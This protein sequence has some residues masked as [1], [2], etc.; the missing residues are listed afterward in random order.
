ML[1]LSD[2]DVLDSNM[3]SFAPSAHK[4]SSLKVIHETLSVFI[5]ATG[6]NVAAKSS[7]AN[8]GA[9]PLPDILPGKICITERLHDG[10][11]LIQWIHTPYLDDDENGSSGLSGGGTRDSSRC[12]SRDSRPS[13]GD[14]TDATWAVINPGGQDG[15]FSPPVNGE[16]PPPAGQPPP[17]PPRAP[18]SVPPP[19]PSRATAPSIAFEKESLTISFAANTDVND[20]TLVLKDDVV[21]V[22]S[23]T[24]TVS[25]N[26]M[27][28]RYETLINFE[29]D[30][31]KSFRRSPQGC[32]WSYLVLILA[33]GTTLPALHFHEG[34]SKSFIL[35]LQNYVVTRQSANDNRLF[36]VSSAEA[37]QRA[38]I[39]SFDELNLF[40]ESAPNLMSKLVNDPVTTTL[41]GFSRVTN[42]LRDQL[43]APPRGSRK[44]REDLQD[45]FQDLPGLMFTS[46]QD[47]PDLEIITCVST[48]SP[49]G[50]S[51]SG[52]GSA[53]S[54]GASAT[55]THDGHSPSMVTSPGASGRPPPGNVEEL[56]PRPSVLRGTPITSK[57]WSKH[58]NSEG[59]VTNVESLKQQI[60]RGGVEPSLR[61]EVW[62]FLLGYYDYKSTY[63]ERQEERKTRVDDYF[64]MKLQWKSL[65]IDQESRFSALKERKA[66]IEKDVNRTDRTH[67]FFQ[68]EKNP[69]LDVLSDVLMTYVMFNFD[70]G[71]VQGMSDLLAPILVV[72]E[73]EVD[74]FWCF[75]G[76]MELIGRNFEMDQSTMKHQMIQL[77][78]ILEFVD[79]QLMEYLENH[80]SGNLYFCFRWLLIHFKR[81]FSFPDIMRIW[82]VLWTGHPCRNFHL[83]ICVALLDSEKG[84]LVENEFGFTEILKHINDMSGTI[85]IETTLRKAEAIFLQI[86]GCRSPPR[87]VA[88]ILGLEAMLCPGMSSGS[89]N[90]PLPGQSPKIKSRDS[91]HVTSPSTA[92]P[93]SASSGSNSDRKS[94]FPDD[95]STPH[96]SIEVLT[97]QSDDDMD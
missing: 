18:T 31:L 23:Q 32:S 65:S 38:L 16:P 28:R 97:T 8:R 21:S 87:M 4:K 11:K 70:L 72:M 59:R 52:R 55:P 45:P 62:K 84:V 77:H 96:S 46:P 88:E 19:L 93:N 36:L 66:L 42:F 79:P 43:G 39:K 92:T 58:M 5:H 67:A 71:Y 47:D 20:A 68:G 27:A 6:S 12:L 64:R 63:K 51:S 30:E 40:S 91:N 73:N 75:A 1:E 49:G 29:L 2:I 95:A 82:E 37:E 9:S 57:E 90:S 26:P 15:T 74:A 13:N 14:A 60:F 86:A 33:D 17:L 22:P 10:Q 56:P 78:A 83:L 81:E 48:S 34:G 41:G 76:F 69:N 50:P 61:I 54:G 25:S 44:Y 35:E 3:Q 89:H 85:D 53:S 80:E 7:E 94:P 24:I